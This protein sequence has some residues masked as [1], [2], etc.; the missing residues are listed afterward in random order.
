MPYS[1]TIISIDYDPA[2]RRLT[3]AFDSFRKV[4]FYDVP[5]SVREAITD[6]PSPEDAFATKLVGKF[7]WTERA[8]PGSGALGKTTD[9]NT[10]TTISEAFKIDRN[11]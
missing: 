1:E 7:A 10:A 9:P 6:A 8:A 3:V 11:L 2:S 5:L 4:V